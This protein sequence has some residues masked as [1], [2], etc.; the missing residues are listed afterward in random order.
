VEEISSFNLIN[1]AVLSFFQLETSSSLDSRW[2][3][4]RRFWRG[5]ISPTG[6]RTKQQVSGG[7][8]SP[9]LGLTKRTF[10]MYLLPF[11]IKN[12]YDSSTSADTAV[13]PSSCR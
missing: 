11:Y 4:P 13:I 8:N 7:V 3:A 2:Q 9:L 10:K 5:V 1:V 12:K 6:T